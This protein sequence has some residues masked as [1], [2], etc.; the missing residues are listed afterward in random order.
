[1]DS[2]PPQ[3]RALSFLK[4]ALLHLLF[5]VR[6]TLG[7]LAQNLQR[8]ELSELSH[9]AR[10][11]GSAASESISHVGAELR[12]INER[13]SKLEHDVDRIGRLLEGREGEAPSLEGGRE[14]SRQ[15]VSD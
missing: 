7:L 8:D 10:R 2:V 4:R 11:L 9:D 5:R 14:P 3:I 12:E 15:S 13:L 6:R 1:M